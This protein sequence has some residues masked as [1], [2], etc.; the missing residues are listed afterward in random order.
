MANE[1]EDAMKPAVK[2]D[3]IEERVQELRSE[4]E[5]LGRWEIVTWCDND[6]VTALERS[7][8]DHTPENVKAVRE[9]F[10]VDSIADRMTEVGFTLIEE[11]ST[12]WD[13]YPI[14]RL[15]RKACETE[16]HRHF[17]RSAS[18][19]LTRAAARVQVEE[20]NRMSTP[21]VIETSNPAVYPRYW[22]EHMENKIAISFDVEQ[23]AAAL[24]DTGFE[25][26]EQNVSAIAQYIDDSSD[27]AHDFDAAFT[28][29]SG[30]RGA[31]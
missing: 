11:Q 19:Q 8:A 23:V 7:G 30:S 12:T 14:G 27:F 13:W 29:S 18:P 4:L 28:P 26:S 9:H 17:T 25:A 15:T 10:Y 24:E 21:I 5:K 1:D 20:E 6:I 22:T 3:A 16:I 31:S 2:E